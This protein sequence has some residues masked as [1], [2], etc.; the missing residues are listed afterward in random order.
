MSL[1][2]TE[3]KENNIAEL[4]IA[5]DA[6]TLKEATDKVFKRK[7]KTINVPGFRKGKAPRAIIEKMYGEGIFMEDAVNDLFP[8][9]YDAAVEE[10]GI[11]PVDRAN[12]EMLTLDKETG[13]TFKATVTV[14]PEVTVTGYKGLEA[15]KTIY[16]IEEGALE[17]EISRM[18]ENNARMLTVED[19]AAADGDQTVIDFLGSVDG[20]PFEGGK[21]DGYQ[22]TLGSHAFIPGFEEQIVGHKPGDEFD[23]NVT[24]PEEYH[25]EELTGKAAVFKVKLHEVKVKELPELDDEFAKDVSEFDTLEELRADLRKQQQD[26]LDKRSDDELETALV[27][28]AI[29]A[30]EGD[31]PECMYEQKIDDMV[32]DFE[33]RL[34]SQGMKIDMYLQYT[35]MDGAAFRQTFREQ[36]ERQVKIR[37]ALEKIAILE[38]LEITEE[39]IDK[40]YTKIADMYGTDVDRVK[41]VVPQKELLGDISCQKAIDLI[42]ANAKITEKPE[43]KEEAGAEA[44]EEAPAEEAAAEKPKPKR[45]AT[46]KKADADAEAAE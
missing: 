3:K 12:V 4:E 7:V 10:A 31:I 17:V 9:A 30:L 35:G 13:F 5:V 27:E 15:V 1:T 22:L 44:L 24:F 45:K 37:L 40:E 29:E 2:S 41:N 39:D 34:S 21:G 46:K 28:K 16:E 20:V 26:E 42:R 38:N 23:V 25:A 6:Q 36:A 32:R 14:K 8:D 33:Y 18:R 43:E 19:R 11:E